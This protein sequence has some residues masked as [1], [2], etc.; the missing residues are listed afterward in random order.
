MKAWQKPEL[1]VLVRNEPAE[2]VLSTC[3]SVFVADG[4]QSFDG[5]CGSIVCTACASISAS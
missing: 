1:I 3:K 5:M 4:P 2:A